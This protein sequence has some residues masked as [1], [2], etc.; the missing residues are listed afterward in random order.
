M[1]A[2]SEHPVAE[3]PPGSSPLP[4]RVGTRKKRGKEGARSRQRTAIFTSRRPARSLSSPTCKKKRE[5]LST[6]SP[7]YSITAMSPAALMSADSRL[8][9]KRRGLHA[10]RTDVLPR[11]SR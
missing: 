9:R 11:S 2:G 8:R 6:G 4:V 7:A 1:T 5:K 3:F 10:Q